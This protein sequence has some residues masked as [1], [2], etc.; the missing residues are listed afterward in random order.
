MSGLKEVLQWPV[1]ADG[2]V[3]VPA[4]DESRAS[5]P[6]GWCPQAP[7]ELSGLFFRDFGEPLGVSWGHWFLAAGHISG[8]D[9]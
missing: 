8:C 5:G 3:S 4:K 2:R 1:D 6:G 7:G 9:M